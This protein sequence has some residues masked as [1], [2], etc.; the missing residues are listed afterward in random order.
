MSEPIVE[1]LLEKRSELVASV[2]KMQAAIF[3][4]D[5]TLAVF[6]HHVGGPRRQPRVFAHGELIA[7]IGDA[8]RSGCATNSAVVE[9]V[10][11]AKAHDP[12]D[13]LLKK[14]IAWSG[15]GLPEAAQREGCV[16]SASERRRRRPAIRNSSNE[17]SSC[18]PRSIAAICCTVASSIAATS[19]SC[20]I[21]E[22]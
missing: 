8:E 15:E 9:H 4:L 3:H 5:E 12:S 10:M 20:V 19:S 6:G 2:A 1:T 11:R 17:A 7:L 16:A 22:R 18:S 21:P 14:R 13:M